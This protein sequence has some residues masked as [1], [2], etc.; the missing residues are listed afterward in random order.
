[1]L[2]G[3]DDHFLY[4]LDAGTG[5]LKARFETSGKIYAS[6]VIC[7]DFVYIGSEDGC[8]Y[9]IKIVHGQNK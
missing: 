1:M 7:D 3:C 5:I 4:A 9:A 6:P 2:F 8:C